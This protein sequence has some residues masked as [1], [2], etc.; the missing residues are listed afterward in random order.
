MQ[1]RYNTY[2]RTPIRRHRI[3]E[4]I[5]APKLR[6][7]DA[8]GNN[9]GILDIEEALRIKEEKGLD[10]IEIAPTASPPVAKIMNYSK[11]IYQQ[12]KRDREGKKGGK[13]ELKEIR[14]AIRTSSNDLGIKAGQVDKFLKKK[15]KVK[16]QLVMQGREKTL[17]DYAR[18]KFTDFLSIIKEPYKT[19]QGLK[20]MPSGMYIMI[21]R[22][23]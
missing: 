18:R 12:A 2:N 3:N 23:T 21:S 22:K 20:N 14:F 9:L 8:D 15:Y 17:R 6:V 11:Y 10:L 19:E 16:I 4:Q 1:R 5:R 7:I 13:S